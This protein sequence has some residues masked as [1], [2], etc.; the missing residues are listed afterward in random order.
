MLE[1]NTEYREE[2]LD[3]KVNYMITNLMESVMNDGFGRSARLWGFN[4]PAAGKTG[5]TD[6]CTDAWFVGFTPELAVGVWS[7]F[8]EKKTMGRK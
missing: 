1:D 2:V 5:T 3:P 7:G 8:D 4:E 6:L